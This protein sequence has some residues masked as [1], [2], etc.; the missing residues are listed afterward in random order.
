MQMQGLFQLPEEGF[1]YFFLIGK[2]VAD[3]HYHVACVGLPCNRDIQAPSW[4][5]FQPRTKLQDILLFSHKGQLPLLAFPTC[6]S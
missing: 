4:L 3:S 1:I 6:P 5:I 2:S